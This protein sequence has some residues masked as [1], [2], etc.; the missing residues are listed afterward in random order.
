ML[1]ILSVAPG[2]PVE[3]AG[4]KLPRIHLNSALGASIRQVDQS[5]LPS[6]E[7]GQG[8][9][10]FEVGF[11]M[12]ADPAFVGAAGGVML[13]SGAAEHLYLAVIHSD[14]HLHQQ[15]SPGPPQHLPQA[16]VQVQSVGGIVEKEVNLIENTLL[17]GF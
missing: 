17:R 14:R 5:G 2:H 3:F 16:I 6:H 8:P 7:R 1:D 9:H 4:G 11:R 10:L 12:V 13:H 15:F